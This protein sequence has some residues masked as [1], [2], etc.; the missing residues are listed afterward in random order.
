MKDQPD[1]FFQ[2][3]EDVLLLKT[4]IVPRSS[5]DEIRGVEDK[6]L[7]I[8][9]SAPPVEGKANKRCISF[10]AHYFGVAPSQVEIT[11]GIKSKNKLIKICGIQ[12]QEFE[13]KLKET[14][15]DLEFRAKK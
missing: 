14:L 9:V 12:P 10:L 2:I 13:E 7:K 3:K 1:D 8:A 5:K 15:K 4:K 11:S 6:V